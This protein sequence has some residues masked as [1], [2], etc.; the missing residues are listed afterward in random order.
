[1]NRE[2]IAERQKT[3]SRNHWM[4]RL[5]K[6]T[7]NKDAEYVGF[8][9]LFWNSIFNLGILPFT[10]CG[11]ALEEGWEIC[12]NLVPKKVKVESES[13]EVI[14]VKP[15]DKQLVILFEEGNESFSYW[16]TN[17]CP[18][19]SLLES[20][21]KWLE[22]NPNWRDFYPAAKE[23]VEKLCK[24]QEEQ[25]EIE[26]QRREKLDKHKEK[27]VAW[28]QHLVKP[29]LIGSALLAV[30]GVY[31]IAW[32]IISS[33][34]LAFV[35]EVL[36]ALLVLVAALITVWV[37]IRILKAGATILK[38]EKKIT[39]ESEG[40]SAVSQAFGAI[41]EGVQFIKDAIQ[42]VYYRRCPLIK[43]TDDETRPIEKIKKEEV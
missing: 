34:S 25:E 35:W 17:C 3:I 37:L 30:W 2:Q 14:P 19:F 31:Q 43:L 8:C 21:N 4:F 12:A 39:Q 33:I 40:P 32:M 27:I 24:I 28:A 38:F 9:P 10:L 20:M 41:G 22:L 11:K 23:R 26:R 29:A 15:S 18:D 36:K 7:W 5:H 1:M 42:I 6:F 13:Q 16:N